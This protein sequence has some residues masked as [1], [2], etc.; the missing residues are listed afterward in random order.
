MS[1]RSCCTCRVNACLSY[2]SALLYHDVVAALHLRGLDPGL[3]LL[4]ATEN[5]RWALALDLME[6][7]RPVLCDALTVRLLTHRILRAKHFHPQEGGIYLNPDGRRTLIE[8]YEQRLDRSFL[9][10]HAGH[11]TTLRQAIVDQVVGFKSSLPADGPAW[12]PF[13]LN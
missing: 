1:L 8:H 13:R 6:P 2:T 11:R 9:S 12:R 4:H 3:G 7:F 10:E 5:G